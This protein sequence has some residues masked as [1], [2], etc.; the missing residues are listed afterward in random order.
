MASSISVHRQFDRKDLSS[1]NLHV[2]CECAVKVRCHP[3]VLVAAET[4]W[5]HAGADKHALA[6][7][8]CSSLVARANNPSAT[9]G[10]LNEWKRRCRVP[11]AIR[12]IASFA[13]WNG[14][15]TVA[16]AGGVPSKPGVYVCVV[17]A[18]RQNAN[19]NFTRSGYGNRHIPID[20]LIV[21]AVA[22][23]HDSFHHGGTACGIETVLLC[24]C[25]LHARRHQ[26]RN[27]SRST[28]SARL[29]PGSKRILAER[30][31]SSA[32]STSRTWRT[33]T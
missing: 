1:G 6:D 24:G 2:L 4:V 23:G 10:A 17:H 7:Q 9:I 33:S 22:G 5:P 14:P 21:T 30:L 8:M 29:W 28:R 32:I 15:G 18:C 13:Q 19:Q 16:Y 11:A 26:K 25:H 12:S 27:C 3:D 31:R 20:E